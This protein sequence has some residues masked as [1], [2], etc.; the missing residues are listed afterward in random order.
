MLLTA[1]IKRNHLKLEMDGKGYIF[2]A[3]FI[4]FVM[5]SAFMAGYSWPFK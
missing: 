3:C 2:L 4:I 1:E 5:F